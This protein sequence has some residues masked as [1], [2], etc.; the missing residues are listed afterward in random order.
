MTMSE[1]PNCG[2]SMHANAKLR[3][4]VVELEAALHSL[5]GGHAASKLREEAIHAAAVAL[6]VVECLDREVK[7]ADTRRG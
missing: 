5:F 1:C 4:R 2:E 3:A 7:C 6:A